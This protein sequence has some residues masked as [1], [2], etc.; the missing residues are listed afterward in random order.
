[1][2]RILVDQACQCWS[3]IGGWGRTGN[4]GQVQIPSSQPF[5]WKLLSDLQR[6]ADK[7]RVAQIRPER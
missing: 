3:G 7:S 1:M 2:G 6:R 5:H 4:L